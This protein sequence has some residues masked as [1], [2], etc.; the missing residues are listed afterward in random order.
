MNLNVNPAVLS[1]VISMGIDVLSARVCT[2][3]AMCM[4]FALSAWTLYQPDYLRIV[5]TA[6]F[7]LIVFLPV[8]ALERRQ[9]QS[10][11]QPHV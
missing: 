11:G 4:M 8:I 2:L 3:T 7:G 1:A 9:I 10:G 6:I 5:E